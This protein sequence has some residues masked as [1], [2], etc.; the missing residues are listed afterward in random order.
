ME[1]E[2]NHTKNHE[3][4][5]F[6][7]VGQRVDQPSLP[8]TT[9]EKN[10]TD[11]IEQNDQIKKDGEILDVIEVVLEFLQGICH[12]TPIGILHLRPPCNAGF[13]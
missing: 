6:A 13:Y 1:S 10:D 7:K 4:R 5:K 3:Q 11:G 9:A 2:A 12:G 8:R